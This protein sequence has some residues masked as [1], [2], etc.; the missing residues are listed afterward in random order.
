MRARRLWTIACA[1]ALAVGLASC[2][3]NIGGPH[4]ADA[5]N[6][7]VYVTAGDVTYQLQISRI[8]NPYGTEDSQYVKGL[9]LG[10]PP[11]TPDQY[12]YGV[13]LWAKNQTNGPLTTSDK[14]VVTDT[15][16]TRY[17]PVKLDADLNPFAWTAQRLYPLQTE[18]APDTPA[19]NGPTQGGLLLFRI[20]NSAF[21][22]RPLTLHILSPENVSL[23]TIS[24]DL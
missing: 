20:S 18:P 7:G 22:N 5:N 11:L 1:L 8:L 21:A 10:T 2:G 23:A 24:L 9:P 15:Q 13:F 12:W 3:G 19:S 16:N 17:Y 6:I 14:F 4:V